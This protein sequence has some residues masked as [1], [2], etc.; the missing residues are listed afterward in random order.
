MK[1]LID[2]DKDYYEIIKYNVEHGQEYKPF[3][4]IANGIPYEKNGGLI[5]REALLNEI[6]NAQEKLK[7]DNDTIWERNRGYFKGLA[8]ANRLII[9]APTIEPQGEWFSVSERL[10]EG[11]INPNTMDFEYVLCSTVWNDV[12]PYKYGKPI[13]H[14]KAH[15]WHGGG[16]MDGAVIAWQPL[17]KPYKEGGES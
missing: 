7:S 17:P 5:S 13:G 4:I 2:V 9:D 11:R 12:R 10:P 16:I 15:F 8:W 6:M 1:L 14:D 3:E